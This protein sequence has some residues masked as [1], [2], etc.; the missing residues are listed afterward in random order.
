MCAHRRAVRYAQRS[1]LDDLRAWVFAAVL[2][3]DRWWSDSWYLLADLGSRRSGAAS[4]TTAATT[5]RERSGN[6]VGDV[7][8]VALRSQHRHGVHAVAVR[9]AADLR[10]TRRRCAT[11]PP[12]VTLPRCWATRSGDPRPTRA[13]SA[14]LV[15]W[16]R[17]LP[18]TLRKAGCPTAARTEGMR[19]HRAAASMLRRGPTKRRARMQT[20]RVEDR[21]TPDSGV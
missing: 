1:S 10:P 11:S 19:A 13:N 18:P 7:L 21:V 16:R 4:D 14:S 5:S 20:E 2:S 17:D 6:Y 12:F 15:R 9:A 8:P 3:A